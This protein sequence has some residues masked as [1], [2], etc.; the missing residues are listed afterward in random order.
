MSTLPA[1][2]I[3]WARGRRDGWAYIVDRIFLPCSELSVVVAETRR[4]LG[5]DLHPTDASETARDGV[6]TVLVF[7]G[8]PV[9]VH[10]LHDVTR[11]R[12]PENRDSKTSISCAQRTSL[13]RML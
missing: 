4:Q 8:L 7:P 9:G 5:N 1:C 11:R 6:M 13:Q 12:N 10:Q 2:G 3:G